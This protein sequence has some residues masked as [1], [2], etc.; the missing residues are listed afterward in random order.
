M[1]YAA[2]A[3]LLI[4][5]LIPA[6]VDAQLI[7][8]AEVSGGW[9]HSTGDGGLDGF[10]FGAGLWFTRR[11]SVGFDYDDTWN[12]SHLTAF[13]LTTNPFTSK[14]HLQ[15]FMIGP[16]LFFGG[17]N[18]KF[19]QTVIP[20]AEFEAGASHLSQ[21]VT[22][23]GVGSTSGSDNAANWFLGGGGDVLLSRRWAARL[24]IGLLRTHFSDS[25]Q[26]RLRFTLGLAYTLGAR[27]AK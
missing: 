27:K 24:N 26:S 7:H 22:Q 9:A 6:H 23:I 8:N 4:A 11:V 25:G 19:L 1:K 20:F 12:S 15:N 2:V 5:L 14:S 3:V 21:T 16:R 10:N 18:V 17:K 13:G